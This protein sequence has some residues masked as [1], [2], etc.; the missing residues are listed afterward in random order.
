M[1]KK[2]QNEMNNITIEKIDEIELKCNKIREN[3]FEKFYC[4]SNNINT[5]IDMFIS[6]EQSLNKNIKDVTVEEIILDMVV[7]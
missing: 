7:V 3:T 5:N 1:A 6:L 2:L 4:N